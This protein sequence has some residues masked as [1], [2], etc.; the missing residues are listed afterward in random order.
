MF[1]SSPGL[2]SLWE[3]NMFE[4]KHVRIVREKLGSGTNCVICLTGTENQNT[5]EAQT[6]LIF[7]FRKMTQ[8]PHKGKHPCSSERALSPPVF[9]KE[10]AVAISSQQ[11]VASEGKAV[12]LCS[13][14]RGRK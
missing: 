7:W 14:R 5:S 10:S 1:F 8:K 6:A 13:T 11:D 12:Y 4:D 2:F 9:T 3:M